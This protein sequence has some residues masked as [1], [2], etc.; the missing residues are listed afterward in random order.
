M[1]NYNFYLMNLGAKELLMCLKFL[2]A[3]EEFLDVQLLMKENQYLNQ[4][5][6]SQLNLQKVIKE[7]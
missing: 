6:N 5:F 1:E 7:D 2:L 4:Y 3:K